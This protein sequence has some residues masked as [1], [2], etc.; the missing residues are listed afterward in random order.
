M[1]GSELEV[2][3]L[4]EK[5]LFNRFHKLPNNTKREELYQKWKVIYDRIT[6]LTIISKIGYNNT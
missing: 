1:V 4:K 5:E 6:A 3:T 2:L